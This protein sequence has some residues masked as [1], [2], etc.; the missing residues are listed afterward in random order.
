[1]RKIGLLLGFVLISTIVIRVNVIHSNRLVSDTIA[2]STRNE[3]LNKSRKIEEAVTKAKT[4]LFLDE[5]GYSSEDGAIQIG[6]PMNLETNSLRVYSFYDI[7]G[8]E[9]LFIRTNLGS[10]LTQPFENFQWKYKDSIL[11]WNGKEL[12]VPVPEEGT[13]YLLYKL[14]VDFGVTHMVENIYSL[15]YYTAIPTT[16]GT[17]DMLME[18]YVGILVEL[19]DS[20]VV[21]YTILNSVID[22]YEWA[23]IYNLKGEELVE[24]RRD[25]L[26]KPSGGDGVEMY[27][28]VAGHLIRLNFEYPEKFVGEFLRF[29]EIHVRS[30][31]HEEVITASDNDTLELPLGHGL[32]ELVL[33]VYGTD[34]FTLETQYRRHM[35]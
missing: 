8:I 22:D 11:E 9:P 24:I 21:A 23:Y 27:G 28:E 34:A 35:K 12:T 14:Q 1:M 33:E 6:N 3:Y 32:G 18:G 13:Q 7:Q 30:S 20:T 10:Q 25:A 15:D 4:D 29:K 31:L 2:Y 17:Y 19:K 16:P 5:R 26:V